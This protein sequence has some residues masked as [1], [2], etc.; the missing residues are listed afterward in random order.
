MIACWTISPGKTAAQDLEGVLVTGR[1]LLGTR[2]V[3]V[4]LHGLAGDSRMPV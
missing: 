4:A 1:R 2:K 3:A